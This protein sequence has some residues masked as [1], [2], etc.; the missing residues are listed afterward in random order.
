M[1]ENTL[2]KRILFFGVVFILLGGLSINSFFDVTY[3]HCEEG[4]KTIGCA[5]IK[6]FSPY[7]FLANIF[8]VLLFSL[9]IVALFSF[10]KRWMFKLPALY[11]IASVFLFTT[12]RYWNDM[13][14]LSMIIS[15]GAWIASLGKVYYLLSSWLRTLTSIVFYFITGFVIDFLVNKYKNDS[16]L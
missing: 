7:D 3:D 6:I 12:G 16:N 14:F 8:L 4:N 10:K 5:P 15:P 9:L 13:G 2:T 11:I 1:E